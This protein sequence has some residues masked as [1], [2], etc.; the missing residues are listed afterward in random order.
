[1]KNII[2]ICLFFIFVQGV[3]LNPRRAKNVEADCNRKIDQLNKSY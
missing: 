1:M 2:L 3:T